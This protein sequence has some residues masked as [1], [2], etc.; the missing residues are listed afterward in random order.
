MKQAGH[1][2]C[3]SPTSVRSLELSEPP[4]PC[5]ENE[6]NN[7]PSLKRKRGPRY[8]SAWKTVKP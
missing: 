2:L 6:N 3:P 5:A 7:T 4:L 8:E 1:Q